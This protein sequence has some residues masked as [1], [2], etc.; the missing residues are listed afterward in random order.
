[1]D[2]IE[3][4]KAAHEKNA[5]DFESAFNDIMNVK[6]QDALGNKYDDMFGTPEVDTEIEFGDNDIELESETEQEPQE[7]E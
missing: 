5:N 6:M 4:V 2:T 7:E 3:L 1:M